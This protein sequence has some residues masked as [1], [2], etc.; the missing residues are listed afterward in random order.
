VITVMLLGFGILLLFLSRRG[1]LTRNMYA[2]GPRAKL[3]F[4]MTSV[5]VNYL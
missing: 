1:M 5:L 3:G 2:S 4:R